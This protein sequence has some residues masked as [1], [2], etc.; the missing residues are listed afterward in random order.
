MFAVRVV[1]ELMVNTSTTILDTV[2]RVGI[3]RFG[4]TLFL[5]SILDSPAGHKK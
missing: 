3:F 1:V 4:K 5:S 2:V